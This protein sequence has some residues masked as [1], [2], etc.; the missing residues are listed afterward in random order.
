MQKEIIMKEGKDKRVVVRIQQ[1]QIEDNKQQFEELVDI[2]N[3]LK[4]RERSNSEWQ[5]MDQ[6]KDTLEMEI[7]ELWQLMMKQSIWRRLTTAGRMINQNLKLIDKE[8]KMTHKTGDI[9][10]QQRCKAFRQLQTRVWD[11]RGFLSTHED[12]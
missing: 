6:P 4:Q 12:T 7:E 11:P 8:R 5:N 9:Q 3:N 1:L 2:N 10:Q